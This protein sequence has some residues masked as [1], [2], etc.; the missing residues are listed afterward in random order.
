V[1]FLTDFDTLLLAHDDR[2]RVIPGPYRSLVMPGRSLVL[3]TFLVDGLV[4]GIWHIER[5]PS[6]ARLII[7]PFEPLAASTS[8]EVQA[9]GQRLLTWAADKMDTFEVV[10]SAYD[11]KGGKQNMWGSL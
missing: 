3:P 10:V 5:T 7:Q 2:Q 4:C 1:R 9:E 11:G 8:Q 6:V